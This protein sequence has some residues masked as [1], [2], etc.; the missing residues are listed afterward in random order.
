MFNQQAQALGGQTAEHHHMAAIAA[1]A[2]TEAQNSSTPVG[3]NRA[4]MFVEST[5]GLSDGIDPSTLER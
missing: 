2:M 3:A 1:P 4:G 5:T